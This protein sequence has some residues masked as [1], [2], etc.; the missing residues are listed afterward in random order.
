M[1]A[2][3][4]KT[5]RPVVALLFGLA[6]TLVVA[7][8]HVAGLDRR[9]ELASLDFRFKY[10]SGAPNNQRI[11]QVKIDENSLDQLGRW[12]W[13]RTELAGI[14]ETLNQC[15]ASVIA[16]DIILPEPQETRYESGAWRIYHTD[17]SALL[18]VGTPLPVFDD[19][20]LAA[21]ICNGG[22]VMVP[23]HVDTQEAGQPPLESFLA[24][25]I[26]ART[27]L[28]ASEARQA[29]S[30]DPRFA[31][32]DAPDEASFTKAYL[33][34]RSLAAL[35]RLALPARQMA[36]FPLKFG[37]II[38][39]LVLFA[40][41]AVASGF[42]TID[43]DFDGVVRRMPL[44]MGNGDRAYLQ[45]GLAM[46]AGELARIYDGPVSVKPEPAAL[47]LVCEG[48]IGTVERRIPVDRDGYM[49][50][51]WIRPRKDHTQKLEVSAA[52]VS[53][54][55]RKKQQLKR[56][57]ARR[58][59]L[60]AELAQK[61]HQQELEGLFRQADRLYLQRSALEFRLQRAELFAPA[62]A[63]A[64]RGA[65]AEARRQEQAVEL[66]IDAKADDLLDE[67]YTQGMSADD[68]TYQRIVAVRREL[69]ENIPQADREIREK[70]DAETA[71]LREIVA[72]KICLMGSTAA[73]AADFVPTPVAKRMPGMATHLNLFN[74][75]ISGRFVSQANFAT[76]ILVILLSG[77]LVSVLAAT[78]PV[79]LAGP[80]TL[81]LGAAYALFNVVVVFGV[82]EVWLVLLAP[83][84][85]MVAAF[86]AVSAYR[87]LTEE[88]A[89]RE[90][91]GLFAHA[92]S[93]TLVDR[94]LEDPS[95]MRL[96]GEKRSV[97]C[98]FSDLA[99]FTP[100]SESLGEQQTVQLLNR[101]FDR[102]TEVIQDRHGG[103]LNKFLGDG[104]LAFFGAPVTQDDHPARAIRAALDCQQAVDDLNVV[105][106]EE[107]GSGTALTCRIGIATGDVM[108]GNCGSTHRM[109]YTAIGD[110][111]NFSSR[112]E[113]ANKA[114]GT[115]I[116]V[117]RES[118]QQAAAGDV[119]A[120]P[121]GRILV[122][123]KNEPVAVWN[124]L[125]YGAE[126]SEPQRRALAEWAMGVEHFAQRD[127]EAA[128]GIF[129][130]LTDSLPDDKAVRVYLDQCRQ[131][132]EDPPGDDWP[133]AL[134]L[135]QK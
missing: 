69:T 104:I 101:Y 54:I 106:G 61:L 98:F 47:T 112:L 85:A 33:D 7:V 8:L 131:Y 3:T 68:P 83:V 78:R 134:Q 100:L 11:V 92:L 39:P 88:R 58:R 45:F 129:E 87:Q 35:S 71:A 118:W 79:W 76:G 90:I 19:A 16:L 27:N 128:A 24:E 15:G 63:E 103:Y 42:V 116:L 60:Q 117:A 94:L 37:R 121:M 56:N 30:G 72:G 108:V 28:A 122:V 96:G 84:V 51:N 22:N 57:A 38:P 29:L 53:A 26:Q 14:I 93:P 62:A 52:Q 55:G 40:K 111:V 4:S 66:Q 124:L 44:L 50:V 107:F 13:P 43:P 133:G 102:M 99:G 12:P 105:L 74:T 6:A 23:M 109:D 2:N 41:H 120:R 9:M 17:D 34:T 77:A 132:A 81:L 25:R 65:L 110:T 59:I 82:L 48:K 126:S 32:D 114:F 67:F 125:G 80:L 86:A 135:M 21:A 1:A 20:A 10:F 64:L 97:T 113:S 127:F 36:V 115:R 73:G 123:G 31:G 95:L 91:R 70:I 130:Q 75:I 119:L 49:L 46:A 89:K 5:S 18:G